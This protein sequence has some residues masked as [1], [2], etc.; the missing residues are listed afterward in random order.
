M[1]RLQSISALM[2]AMPVVRKKFGSISVNFGVPLDVKQHV[3]ATLSRAEEQ[4]TFVPTSAIV[5]DLGYA[6]TDALIDNA[7][8]AMS[9]VVA[10]ILL[11]YRQGI[12][13]QELVRQA[14]WLRLEILRRGGRVVGTQ[15][16]SP[17][18]VVDRA[19]E[20]LHELVTMRRK[21]LVEPAITSVS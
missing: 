15:G 10:A 1:L 2:K 9:H 16:R 11:V 12:S 13:K 19:L 6:I 17:T 5:E 21:D 20:L 4:E 14:D 8:C 18:V 7:T 3:D